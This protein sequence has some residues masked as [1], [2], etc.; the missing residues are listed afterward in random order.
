MPHCALLSL[1]AGSRDTGVVQGAGSFVQTEINNGNL[2]YCGK[3]SQNDLTIVG[4]TL[5]KDCNRFDFDG[6]N[7]FLSTWSKTFSQLPATGAATRINEQFYFNSN[8]SVTVNIFYVDSYLFDNIDQMTIT[9]AAN[10]WVIINVKGDVNTFQNFQITVN[11][12]ITNNRIIYNF[13]ETVKLIVQDI[14]VEV[15]RAYYTLALSFGVVWCAA[16]M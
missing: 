5:I 12:G 13:F 7:A 4:G 16:F 15:R 3:L 1:C 10:Q 8:P 14:G 6:T 2:V 11:G 9:A